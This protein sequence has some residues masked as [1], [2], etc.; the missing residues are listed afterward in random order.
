MLDEEVHA[1]LQYKIPAS[2]HSIDMFKERVCALRYHL[3]TTELK[4]S[5]RIMKGKQKRA[6][7][8]ANKP[9]NKPRPTV[10]L[11]TCKDFT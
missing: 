11:G 10:F 9:V 7:G 6:S 1:Y 8:W 5:T 4:G 2:F 3:K